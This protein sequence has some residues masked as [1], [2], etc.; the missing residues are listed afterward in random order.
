MI[1]R[2]IAG[3]ASFM[4]KSE[5]LRKYQA[6]DIERHDGAKYNGKRDEL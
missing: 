5:I 3:D 6:D 1:D 4:V 2:F